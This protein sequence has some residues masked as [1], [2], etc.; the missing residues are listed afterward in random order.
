MPQKDPKLSTKY[1]NDDPEYTPGPSS[2][3]TEGSR[4]QPKRKAKSDSDNSEKQKS[5]DDRQNDGSIID[6][7]S[8]QKGN[9]SSDEEFV[10]PQKDEASSESS[11]HKELI[12]PDSSKQETTNSLTHT[13]P[14]YSQILQSSSKMLQL[15]EETIT[16][17]V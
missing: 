14:S 5:D 15:D 9:I 8:P 11:P 13:I 3:T 4:S 12:Q 7:V 16:R 10:S 6:L 2:S 1:E 17:I